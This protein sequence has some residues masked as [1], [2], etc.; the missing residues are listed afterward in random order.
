MKEH[1]FLRHKS[2]IS[3]DITNFI[4]FTDIIETREVPFR[5]ASSTL[6]LSAHFCTGRY[7]TLNPFQP[8]G[9]GNSNT[10]LCSVTYVVNMV[11]SLV[12]DKI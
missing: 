7:V 12:V 5:I 1:S 11:F 10:H 9:A 2:P 3:R 4:K 6:N 8:P